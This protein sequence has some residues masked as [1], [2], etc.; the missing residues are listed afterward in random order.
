MSESSLV[1]FRIV[2]EFSDQGMVIVK[3]QHFRLRPFCA[4]CDA[5]CSVCGTVLLL[6]NTQLLFCAVSVTL[7][8]AVCNAVLCC[9]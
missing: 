7:F 1:D 4:V 9:L 8:C 5:L 6:Y 2:A 3:T